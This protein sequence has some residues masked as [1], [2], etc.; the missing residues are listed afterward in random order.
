MGITTWYRFVLDTI[1]GGNFYSSHSMD[2]FNAMAN[3]VG[4]PPITI[5]E[6]VLTLEHVMQRIDAIE[7]K[8]PTI[9]HIENFNKMIHN[10]VTQIGSKV[11]IILKM[12]K[13]KEPIINK[14][15][16]QSPVRIDKLEEIINNLGSAFFLRQNY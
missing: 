3:L 16:E 6:T 1:T 5:S 12:L 11:G 8:M 10:H 15:V 7:K 2:A 9:E 14:R 13:E 4:S